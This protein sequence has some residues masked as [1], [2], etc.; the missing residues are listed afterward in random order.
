MATEPQQ[1][2]ALD[3]GRVETLADGVFAIAMTLLVFNINVPSLV[4]AA[5]LPSKLFALWPRVLSYVISFVVLGVY[6]IGHHNQFAYIRRADRLFLWINILFLMCVAFIP[7]SAALLGQYPSQPIALVEYGAN[8]IVVGAVLFVHWRYATSGRR[9][10]DPKLDPA[11]IRMASRRILRAPVA[12]V[13]AVALAFISVPVSL[14]IYALVPL[15]YILPGRIDQYWGRQPGRPP[16]T[17][18]GS[19]PRNGG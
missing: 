4:H 16:L 18:A 9:L 1:R 19:R 12:Y 17:G 5:E 8:L 2:S 7:F 11:L 10:V 14:A 15:L 6:W 3:T 13:G